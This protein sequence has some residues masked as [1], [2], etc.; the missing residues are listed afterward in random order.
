MHL[1]EFCFSFK[2]WHSFINEIEIF[3]TGE[4]NTLLSIHKAI[5]RPHLDYYDFI[6]D[7]PHNETFIDHLELIQYNAT[8]ARTGTIK[9]ASKEKI[10]M[11]LAQNNLGESGLVG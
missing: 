1:E 4:G 3:Y 9:G 2:Q 6:Y 10:T 7:M 11:N 5:L 8:V